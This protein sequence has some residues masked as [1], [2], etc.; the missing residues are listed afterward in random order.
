MGEAR[1]G[2]GGRRAYPHPH[3]GHSTLSTGH[4]KRW[5]PQPTTT[6]FALR[7]LLL[8]QIHPGFHHRVGVQGHAVDTLFHQP[9]GEIRMVGRAL[10]ADADVLALLAAGV[11]GHLQQYPHRFVALVEQVCHQT[12]VAVQTQRQ[13]G[14]VVGA[15]GETVEVLEELVGEQGVGRNLAH[16]DDLETV[17]TALQTVLGQQVDDLAGFVRGVYERHHQL[18][19]GQAH[20]VAHALH[21]AAFQLE[22]L[23]EGIGNVARRPTEAQHR[24]FFGRLVQGAADHVGVLVRFEIRHAYDDAV[25]CKGSRD[26]ADALNQLVDVK[27]HRRGV[28]G[29]AAADDALQLLVE[30]V[31]LQQCL[32]VDADHA[33]DDELQ[34]RKPHTVVGVGL[35]VKGAVGVADVH[36]D[37]EG[38]LGQFFQ[39]AG[40][41]LEAEDAV[42]DAA[43]IALGTADG[44]VHAG[45]QQVGSVATAHH[46]RNAQFAG[47]DR[48]V[49]GAATA[50][51]YNCRS[52]LH[53]RFPVR[54]GHIGHQHVAG[55]NLLHVGDALHHAHG[56][57]ADALA[58]G[59]TFA[60]HLTG[61]AQ[62]V[63]LHH[64]AGGTALYGLRTGLDDVEAT[65]FAIL[66]PLDIHRALVVLLD[67]HGLA[68]QGFHFGV[69]Q[70]EALTVGRVDIDD[71]HGFAGAGILGVDHLDGLGAHVATQDRRAILGQDLFADVELV[72]VHGTQHDGFTEA[73][74]RGD[75]DHLVATGFGVQS[76]HHA[77]GT[78][79]GAHHALDTGGQGD[80]LVIEVLVDAV[81][82]GAVVEQ[83]GKHL[84]DRVQHVVD[85]ANV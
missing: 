57:A 51:G 56:T 74:G 61:L 27:I 71:L 48:R 10:A 21:G 34:A 36:H 20:V 58:D 72:R 16:H 44:H 35:E 79:F 54:V 4:K 66:C 78:G 50:V 67:D 7:P 38:Q 3:N 25:R 43:G 82:D 19:V 70:R 40:V 11:D 29:H 1:F 31:E 49:T 22:A 60:Q 37:L 53:N 73:V 32:G 8:G 75:E 62:Q 65:V 39:V 15:D 46:R 5:L 18:D 23:A 76:E 47:D 30:A 55:L 28:A 59:A 77:G 14:Q 84:L 52:A 6:F 33:V 13:L 64:R 45:F 69:A 42:V 63:A 12:G 85:A 26:G 41:D 81:G 24:V 17:F 9:M 2:E 68:R 83:G 80:A